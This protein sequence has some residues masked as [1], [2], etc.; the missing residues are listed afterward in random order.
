MQIQYESLLYHCQV[1]SCNV[2]PGNITVL[3]GVENQC[4]HT[5]YTLQV[6]GTRCWLQIISVAFGCC[7][8]PYL[9]TDLLPILHPTLLVSPQPLHLTYTQTYCPFY[10]PPC[11]SHPTLHP[12]SPSIF[13]VFTPRPSPLP[14]PSSRVVRPVPPSIPSRRD[15]AR[16]ILGESLMSIRQPGPLPHHT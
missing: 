1:C 6:V 14:S 15:K 10:T 11:R 8:T 5:S 4:S 3:I 16:L 12:P 9:Y 2:K 7:P 13:P